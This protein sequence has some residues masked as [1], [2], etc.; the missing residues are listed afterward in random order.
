MAHTDALVRHV[1]LRYGLDPHLVSALV[2]VESRGQVKAR[3]PKGALG[4][5]QIMPGTGKRYGVHSTTALLDPATNVETGV[6]Y[7][8]DLMAMFP[9]RTDLVLAAYNAGEG[10]VIRYGRRIPPYAETQAYVRNILARYRSSGA[11]VASK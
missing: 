5:M 1:S 3:S 9:G 4:L 11:T 2:F 7:L 10:A 6:R 8:R